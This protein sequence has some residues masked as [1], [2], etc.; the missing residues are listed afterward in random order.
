MGKIE[1][2]FIEEQGQFC[3]SQDDGLDVFPLEERVGDL[4]K[5]LVLHFG[6]AARVHDLQISLVNEFDLGGLSV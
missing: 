6:P 4:A 5:P 1:I 3:A 2:A